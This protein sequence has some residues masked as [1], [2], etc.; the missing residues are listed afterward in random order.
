MGEPLR[1][2]GAGVDVGGTVAADTGRPSRSTVEIGAVTVEPPSCAPPT[3]PP[4]TGAPEGLSPSALHRSADQVIATVR[5]AL[6][7]VVVVLQAGLALR[8]V[9]EHADRGLAVAAYAALACVTASC[10]PWV[11]RRRTVP[12][13]VVAAGTVVVLAALIAAVVALPAADRFGPADWAAG[14]VGWFLLLLLLDRL[15]FFL[16]AFGLHLV[17]VIGPVLYDAPDRY[18]LGEAGTVIIGNTVVQLSAMVIARL[19][20]RRAREAMALAAERDRLATRVLSAE[21]WERGR[22]TAFAGHLGAS[23]SLLADLADGLLDPRDPATRRW[24]ALAATQLRRLFAENDDVPD[25]LVHEVAACLDV[26]ER[27]G[28]DV[29]L[30]VSGAAV[31]VPAP[32]RRELTGPV[33]AALA[34]AGTRARV[35]VLRADGDVRVAV[36]SDAGTMPAPANSPE[37]NIECGTYGD[38]TRMEARWRRQI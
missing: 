28:L 34:A 19:V 36:V 2:D 8:P 26:A 21:Q 14:L 35:S 24:A 18:G 9:L 17:V 10:A 23:L 27:R 6:F 32:I 1:A 5:V 4:L 15:P 3:R 33:A 12:V 22:R 11:L 31:D 13:P 37:V 29:S 30:A 38:Y 16:T 20:S 25:P 7:C